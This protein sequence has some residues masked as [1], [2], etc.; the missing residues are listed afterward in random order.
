VTDGLEKAL[1]LFVILPA[2]AIGAG[3]G[4]LLNWALS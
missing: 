2:L 4:L 1:F 3:A